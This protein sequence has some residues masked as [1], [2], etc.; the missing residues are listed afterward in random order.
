MVPL[1][2]KALQERPCQSERTQAQNAIR[3]CVNVHSESHRAG[4]H[5][6]S[7]YKCTRMQR[8]CYSEVESMEE[9]EAGKFL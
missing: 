2:V 1:D 7:R 8:R 9:N 6:Q 5:I 4:A 3:V